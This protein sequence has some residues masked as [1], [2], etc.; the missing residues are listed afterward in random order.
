[1][2]MDSS[3]EDILELNEKTAELSQQVD[4]MKTEW[5]RVSTFVTGA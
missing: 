5:N 2:K 4:F 3:A 1:M